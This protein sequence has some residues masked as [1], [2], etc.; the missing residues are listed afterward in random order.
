V[1]RLLLV[2]NSTCHGKGYL[3]HCAEQILT[4]LN[5]SR[6]RVVFVPFAGGDWEAYTRKFRERLERMNLSV[7]S[8]S[9]AADA[10]G[11]RGL[12]R[13][14]D[15]VFVGGGNTFRLLAT[16]YRF[17]LL[18]AIRNAVA[19][20]VC[21]MGAS[22]GVNVACPTIK[23]TN[24]MPIVYPPSFD[25][26]GLVPFNIN[27]HYFDADPT[28]THMGETRAHRIAEFHELN[29]V[30]VLGL[31]EGA[32]IVVHGRQATLAGETGARL[33]RKGHGPEELS[34][35]ARLDSLM[36]LVAANEGL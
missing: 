32:M 25:A 24:D 2:S 35:G 5:G 23:T 9:E 17:D 34:P 31:R 13:E 33:F 15:A 21:Y 3:D 16:L 4:L 20:G 1:N 11:M 29:D 26:L 14:A 30:P 18:S 19:D 10:A 36:G 12:L 7:R 8:V 28:S 22:A 27:P 6:R